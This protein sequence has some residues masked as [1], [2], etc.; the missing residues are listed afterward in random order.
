MK[1]KTVYF[2]FIII[3]FCILTLSYLYIG[4][5]KANSELE[6]FDTNQVLT[7]DNFYKY[8]INNLSK[9][10]KKDADVVLNKYIDNT[11]GL[12]KS[13]FKI[14]YNGVKLYNGIS[15]SLVVSYDINTTFMD[16]KFKILIGYYSLEV[17]ED[18]FCNVF[19]IDHKF[20]HL[21][22]NW[23]KKQ[24][25][26]DDENV[27]FGF[28]WNFD[29]PYIDF[30]KITTLSEDYREVFENTHN[31]YCNKCYINNLFELNEENAKV[32]ADELRN[33]YLFNASKITGMPQEKKIS[34]H[35]YMSTNE[36]NSGSG[37]DFAF[38]FDLHNFSSELNIF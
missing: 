22:S 31:L 8:K 13:H 12:T 7:I 17:L 18:T 11:Y 14:K 28:A 37:S 1:K 38:I 34:G 23:V 16:N 33:K 26:I 24:V 6:N 20:Q 27:E 4:I 25:W 9:K 15:D 21:Y 2:L 10:I 35:I 5:K 30:D 36:F 19:Y 29:D 32:I 3:I